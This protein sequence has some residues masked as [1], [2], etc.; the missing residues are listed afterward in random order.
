MEILVKRHSDGM[1]KECR[2][3]D[4]NAAIDSG[5]LSPAEAKELADSF[6][7]AAMDLLANIERHIK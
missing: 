7:N 5:L 2:V 4:G 3:V 6:L 1:Y